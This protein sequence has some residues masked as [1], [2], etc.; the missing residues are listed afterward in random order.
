MTM[1]RKDLEATVF[2]ILAVAVY[3]AQHEGWSLPVIGDSRRWAA[4]AILV[5]G[6]AA[7]SRGTHARGSMSV[8]PSV[9]G[10][11]ALV[12]GVAAIWTAS[13][14][15]LSLLIADVVLLWVVST[16]RHA[17]RLSGRPVATH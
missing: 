11:A 9:L 5:L 15:S 12:L 14:R 6:M 8:L 7:C 3:A 16:W 17:V 2:T 10:V 13:M 4:G 1:T